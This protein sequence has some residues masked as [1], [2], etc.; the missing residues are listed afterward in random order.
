VYVM[1]ATSPKDRRDAAWKF[2]EFE[3]S[4]ANQLWKWSRMNE[5]G[6]PVFP[7]AFSATT[8]VANLPEFAMV[9]DALSYA[10]VE[11][12]VT[13]WPQVREM[14]DEEPL[15]A[16]LLDPYEDPAA[17]LLAHSRKA[18]REIFEKYDP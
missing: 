16:V 3:L 5:L 4:P 12:D 13:G 6:M 9:Q 18:D 11:P 7:G 17:L 8:D 15:Q 10:R 14:L 1:N 2:I